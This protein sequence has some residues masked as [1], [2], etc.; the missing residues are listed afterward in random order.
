MVRA[1]QI[2]FVEV[3]QPECAKTRPEQLNFLMPP[4]NSVESQL[5]GPQTPC[6]FPSLEAGRTERMAGILFWFLS[7]ESRD[8]SI[9]FDWK[10]DPA[11]SPL[12]TV[13]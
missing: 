9:G 10:T 4:V 1:S 8:C 6:R 3:Q 7:A 5:A 11:E 2:K 12:E 13:P